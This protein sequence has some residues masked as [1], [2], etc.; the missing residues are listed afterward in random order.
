MKSAIILASLAFLSL[1]PAA[2]AT[3]TWSFYETGITSC[4]GSCVLPPQ[5]FVFATLAMPGPTSTGTAFWDGI[6]APVYT[7]DNFTL[8][9]GPFD[10]TPA[11]AGHPG[12]TLCALPRA[13]C[14]FDISWAETAGALTAVSISIDGVN[15]DIGRDFSLS[16]GRI[17]SDGTLGGCTFT[18]CT[19]TGFWQSDLLT[20]F[21][22]SELPEPSSLAILATGFLALFALRRR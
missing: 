20:S 15:D 1:S 14:D 19:I 13:A 6:G 4:N 10:I 16:G 21:S 3:V 2:D 17:A 22:Q 9:V 12:E 5:P 11:F 8:M 7:G 18:Q